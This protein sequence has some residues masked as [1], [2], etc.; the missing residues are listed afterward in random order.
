MNGLD[1]EDGRAREH[2]VEAPHQQVEAVDGQQGRSCSPRGGSDAFVALWAN[3]PTRGQS[4]LPAG[5]RAPVTTSASSTRWKSKTTHRCEKA[6]SPATARLK[7]AA[8]SRRTTDSTGPQSSSIGSVR[9]PPIATTPIGY[10]E[11]SWGSA[12]DLTNAAIARAR[13]SPA[14][15]LEE[16]PPT[17]DGRVAVDLVRRRCAPA[18][19]DRSLW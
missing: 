16:V 18:A 7:S 17:H 2:G 11:R 6:S 19:P 12:H 13:S 9:P 14:V 8:S 5:C 10:R 15:L 3:I 4:G 1:I